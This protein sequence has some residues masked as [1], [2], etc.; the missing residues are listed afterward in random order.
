MR[1]PTAVASHIMTFL[2]LPD[3]THLEL[4]NRRLRA[5]ARLPSTVPNSVELSRAY[6]R[7]SR[8]RAALR[9]DPLI[10]LPLL[11]DFPFS[12]TRVT[13]ISMDCPADIHW[14][15]MRSIAH[16][17]PRLQ[18]LSVDIPFDLDKRMTF[19]QCLVWLPHLVDF[20]L[21]CS[22]YFHQLHCTFLIDD[23]L[24]IGRSLRT[25][26]VS[27]LRLK[28]GDIGRLS[29]AMPSLTSL[30]IEFAFLSQ[31]E[32]RQD[33]KRV[34]DEKK[35]KENRRRRRRK[36]ESTVKTIQYRSPG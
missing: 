7:S 26:D 21:N 25:L 34:S 24:P 20:H 2:S 29:F 35:K 10:E 30:N 32:L 28:R 22:S 17:F 12:G 14:S 4:G 8:D 19:G 5:I 16:A 6:L 36:M 18:S 3:I 9:Y 13:H 33:A 27:F 1:L 15:T 31:D 11:M 23:S